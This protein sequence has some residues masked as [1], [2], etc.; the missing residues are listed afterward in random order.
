[1]EELRK[2]I[3]DLCHHTPLFRQVP[4]LH[5]KRSHPSVIRRTVSKQ[6]NLLRNW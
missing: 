2:I 4:N 1:M 5:C 3:I 6:N